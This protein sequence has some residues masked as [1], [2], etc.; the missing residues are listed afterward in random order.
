MSPEDLLNER[1][2]VVRHPAA[3]PRAKRLAAQPFVWRDPSKIP[4]RQWLYGRVYARGV[5]SVLVAP[6]GVGKSTLMLGE[7]LAMASGR[8]LLGVRI[9][10]S[11]KLRVAYWN[12]EDSAE[13][14]ERRVAAAFIGHNLP[15]DAVGDRLFIMSAHDHPL[16][17]VTPG[18]KGGHVVNQADAD[19]LAAF[20][21][22]NRIDVFMADPAIDLHGCDENSNGAMDALVKTLSRTGAQSNCG[23]A[24]AHHARKPGASNGENE[25]R[26]EDARG[27]KALI[28]GARIARVLNVMRKDEAEQV[29]VDDA[30]RFRYFRADDG[31]AN[32]APRAG[33]A[34][35][36][37]LD[38]VSL[39]NGTD[40]Y[41]TGDEIGC[42]MPW[43]MPG[44]LASVTND[45]VRN[46]QRKLGQKDYRTSVQANDWAGR[47]VADE[48]GL[49]ADD[50]ADKTKIKKL[51][52]AWVKGGILR[53]EDREDAHRKMRPCYVPG[54]APGEL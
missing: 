37:R 6:G 33:S 49:D 17:L 14:L 29:G 4:P 50:E 51:L 10:G 36:F 15:T 34:K 19:A 2:T 13:E 12:G 18:D 3:D 9:H 43:E 35:W 53:R 7:A 27:A 26:V 48:L 46:I 28:D 32:L 39:N 45:N 38:S 24:L 11:R 16:K 5:V 54:V 25:T 23:M 8:E 52:A 47:V 22:A 21:R 40:D 41:P 30:D 44:L 20:L 42:V 1:G 31:K